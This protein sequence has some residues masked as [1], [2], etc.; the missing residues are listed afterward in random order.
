[1]RKLTS[2]FLVVAF[3]ACTKTE[4]TPATIQSSNSSDVKTTTGHKR[5]LLKQGGD[6]GL[7]L[8]GNNFAYNP[9]DTFVLT[10]TWS[11]CTLE[12]VYGAPGAYVVI[13]NQGSQVQLTDGFS[14]TNCRYVRLLGKG[15]KD[16][17][18]FR[19][20]ET[21]NDGVGITITGR[22][23]YVE[24]SNVDIYNKTYGYWVK[25]EASCADSL[26]YPN[27]IIN[28]IAIHDGRIRVTNQEGM[29]MG[30]TD[31][32]GLRGI[33]CNGSTIYPKPLRLGF[34]NVFRMI[35]DSTYRSGIQLSCASA[36]INNIHDNTITNNGYEYNSNGQG[37]GISLG[38]YTQANLYNNTISNTYTMGIS[39][40]GAGPVTIKNNTVKYS[41]SLSGHTVPGMASIMIDTRNTNPADSTTFGISDNNLGQN[42]DVNIRVYRTYPTYTGKNIICSNGSANMA[43]DPGVKWTTCN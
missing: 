33:S 36:G 21:V 40:L 10:G 13:I 3:C 42:T 1:M 16:K 18:G 14:L 2:F 23:S 31:P 38:G 26:Q 4:Q 20:A 39:S 9:G 41:G 28:H 30:S 11:Y 37:S 5:I 43:V 24:V 8:N 7:Y 19:I 12:D 34:I 17:Y 15:T 25:Q 35:I 6:N 22:S 27:W 29:Y 32:N